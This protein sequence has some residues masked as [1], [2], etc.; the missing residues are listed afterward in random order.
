MT[1]SPKDQIEE[2][3]RQI[4]HHDHCYYVLDR[5]E[6]SD[7]AYDRLFRQL[8]E[9]EQAYP[10]FCLAHSPTQRVGGRP[11]DEFAK[12]THGLPMLS[13]ANTLSEDEF[14][15]FDERVHRF[16][17]TPEDESL[18]YFC[19]LKFDGLSINLVYEN[20]QLLSAATRGD[21]ET[22]E[23]VTQNIRTIRSIPLR[24]NTPSPPR[25]IEIRGEILLP[26]EAFLQLNQEQ[27]TK[28][29]KLFANPRN[30]AAGSVRQ[31]DPTIAAA[32]PL[33]GFFYGL[34]AVDGIRFERMSELESTLE[35]WG[36]RV[37]KRRRVCRGVEGV[38]RFYRE[39]QNE[40]DSLPYEI[41]GIVVKLNRV[42]HLDRAGTVARSP[43][44]MVAFKYPP[45]QE[46]TVIEDIIVQVGRTGALTPVAIVTPVQLG[47]ATI[48]RA[49][50]HNQDEIDRKDIR[51]GDR[52]LIQR[53][54]DVIPE[55]VQVIT[56]ARTGKERKFVLPEHC[57][58]CESRV[59]R[60]AGEAVARCVSR[61]CLAQLKERLRHLVMKDAI[62]IEGLGEKIVE[63]LV[64]Q[65]LVK[66]PAD[67]FR[68]KLKDLLQLEG[69]GEKSSQKLL[70]AIEF[71][72]EPALYRLIFGL[73]IRHV[74]ESTS[75]ILAKHFGSIE[76]LSNAPQSELLQVEEIGPE[77]ARSIR[78]HFSHSEYRHEIEDLL[79]EVRPQAPKIATTSATLSGMTFVLTGT[80]PT[81]SRADAT[82]LIEEHGGKVSTSVSKKTHYL[83]AGAE[84]G[85]KLEKAQSLGVAVLDEQGL[86]QLAQRS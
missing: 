78:E 64:D 42:D 39:V 76:K 67:L 12:L 9:L 11:L 37:G 51:I 13:L 75:K 83:V 14:R 25:R 27:S 10:Q 74:G 35:S 17:D 34:G 60:R 21:G 20:G 48:R 44:G 26:I 55:V 40:R 66:H 59:E 45:R 5:P 62:D 52:V 61:N 85:S 70:A 56:E 15:A 23:D 2:L 29:Q 81:L 72:R 77:V 43:R 36:F 65:G 1:L 6:I 49:T 46:T 22:G 3:T 53:A 28:G 24:L 19:E 82:R 57:P 86:I 50:L 32:R 30:A 8:Q 7:A 16:L 71:A 31:L 63:Q 69:F 33:T 38:L 68:L 54:G 41:D 80:L 47:G 4:A 18:E 79:R 58:V 73:G 84:A